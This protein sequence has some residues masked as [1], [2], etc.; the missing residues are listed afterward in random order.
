M[1]QKRQ[2]EAFRRR[3][4]SARKPVYWIPKDEGDAMILEDDETGELT[5]I[6]CGAVIQSEREK[7]NIQVGERVGIKYLG[8]EKGY[9]NFIVMVDRAEEADNGPG[10]SRKNQE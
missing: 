1:S 9:K 3:V 8:D 7:Q 4:M 2:A 5:A 10:A 6:L